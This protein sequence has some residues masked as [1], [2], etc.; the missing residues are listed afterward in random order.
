[1]QDGN[2]T[3]AYNYLLKAQQLDPDHEQNLINLAVWYHTNKRNPEAER[4][5]IHLLQKHPT[6]EQAKAM[7]A[8]LARG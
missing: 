4:S 1:M 5:L 8:D 6:N 3:M 2:N 7:L